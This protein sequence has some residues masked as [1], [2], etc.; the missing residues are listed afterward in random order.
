MVKREEKIAADRERMHKVQASYR[1]QRP[2][3]WRLAYLAYPE[4]CDHHPD[5]IKRGITDGPLIW[6]ECKCGRMTFLQ[7]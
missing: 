5:K 3:P 1:M 4:V 2:R 6:F 7:S